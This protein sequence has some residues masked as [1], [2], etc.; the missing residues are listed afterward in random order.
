MRRENPRRLRS[1]L[2]L[3]AA[4]ADD[5][6]AERALLARLRPRRARPS[7]RRPAASRSR[8]TATASATGA[9]GIVAP[10]GT[11]PA[12]G[13]RDRQRPGHAD[14][15]A[16]VGRQHA[17]QDLP[18]ETPGVPA[19]QPLLRDRPAVRGRLEAVRQGAARLGARPGDL[20]LRASAHQRSAT[21]TPA[22]PRTAWEAFN[23]RRGVCRD[24]AH[25]AIAFCR[26]MNIP[27]RYCTGYLGDI[28]VPPRI[29][30]D[31]LRRLVRGLSRRPLAHVRRRATTRRAS[32]AS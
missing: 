26:C 10:A 7:R 2:R 9:A 4:D 12:S 6:D 13:R 1:R 3:P 11:A 21:S 23:E 14:A 19:G 25:L 20:R 8:P 17:V 30:P 32:A 27:A 15:V 22:R 18:D 16:P 31:G 24:F 5:P 29:R 28:G